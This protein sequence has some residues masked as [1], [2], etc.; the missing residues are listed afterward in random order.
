MTMAELCNHHAEMRYIASANDPML[1]IEKEVTGMIKIIIFNTNAF[2]EVVSKCKSAVYL[3][4]ENGGRVNICHNPHL[5]EDLTYED[6]PLRLTLEIP[7]VSDY[8]KIVCF[9]TG[10]I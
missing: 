10:E 6:T 1:L 8:M 3:I 7:N 4:R 5:Q 9:T 2:L